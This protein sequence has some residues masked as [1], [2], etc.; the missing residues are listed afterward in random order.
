MLPWLLLAALLSAG[1]AS[2]HYDVQLTDGSVFRSASKPKLTKEG[3]YLVRNDAGQ[4]GSINTNFVQQI[5]PVSDSKSKTDPNS[6][7]TKVPSNAAK[8]SGKPNF[9]NSFEF[10]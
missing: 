8:P 4:S 7:K 3:A 1:C 2:R 10:R 5:A 9:R 6:T